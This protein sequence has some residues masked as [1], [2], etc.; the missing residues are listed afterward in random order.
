MA[1]QDDKA[2]P[3]KPEAGES[4]A[5][6]ALDL[7]SGIDAGHSD[8]DTHDHSVPHGNDLLQAQNEAD[9]ASDHTDEG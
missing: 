6:S 5:A 7:D 9:E 3:H 8:Q 4:S 1:E 2:L